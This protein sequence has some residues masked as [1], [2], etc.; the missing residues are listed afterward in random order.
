MDD[1]FKMVDSMMRKAVQHQPNQLDSTN[2]KACVVLLDE[3]WKVINYESVPKSLSISVVLKYE[4]QQKVIQLTLR[5]QKLWMEILAK[6]E[7]LRK[8]AKSI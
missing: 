5:E 3:G 7:E 6:R 2:I 4:G 8:N 1:L